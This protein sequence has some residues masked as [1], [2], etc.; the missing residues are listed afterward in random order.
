MDYP[1]DTIK[2]TFDRPGTAG[3]SPRLERPGR[4]VSQTPDFNGIVG[5]GSYLVIV[6]HRFDMM[7]IEV[8]VSIKSLNLT[9][10]KPPRL[11]D[12]QYCA[13]AMS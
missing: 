5:S 1:Q 3:L 2:E 8:R 4:L 11:I 7:T 6:N 13:K 10:K 9:I 12:P